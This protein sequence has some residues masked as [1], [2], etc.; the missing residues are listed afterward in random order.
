M[1]ERNAKQYKVTDIF[2]Q[3]LGEFTMGHGLYTQLMN[4]LSLH[5]VFGRHSSYAYLIS[6]T[7]SSTS[8]H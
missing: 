3:C 1:Y 6:L 2:R 4:D 7:C 8:K 5:N